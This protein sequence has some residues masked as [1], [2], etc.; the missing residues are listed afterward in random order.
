MNLI[1]ISLQFLVFLVFLG[2]LTI[3]LCK[4]IVTPTG[5]SIKYDEIL[6]LKKPEFKEV[7]SWLFIL[8]SFSLFSS[9]IYKWLEMQ[10]ILNLQIK[11]ENSSNLILFSTELVS[12]NLF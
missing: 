5:K 11:S 6:P 1:I 7:F 4:Y 8:I 3:Y 2:L 12:H 9:I 10:M